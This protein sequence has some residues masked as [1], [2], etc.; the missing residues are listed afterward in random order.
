MNTVGICLG[1]R[2]SAKFPKLFIAPQMFRHKI[3]PQISL[4]LFVNCHTICFYFVKRQKLTWT[5]KF[6]TNIKQNKKFYIA[7]RSGRETD[8]GCQSITSEIKVVAKVFLVCCHSFLGGKACAELCGD[9][10][11][12]VDFY[13][14]FNVPLWENC[15]EQNNIFFFFRLFIKRDVWLSLS[16]IREEFTISLIDFQLLNT[17]IRAVL[18][19]ACA[20]MTVQDDFLQWALIAI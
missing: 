7:F 19:K 15:T 12:S 8:G 4:F 18:L 17:K 16:G 13:G 9:Q 14:I 20:G 5:G 3:R 11:I 10:K 2:F 1:Y 6:K